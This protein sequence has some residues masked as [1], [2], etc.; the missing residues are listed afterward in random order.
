MYSVRNP[1]RPFRDGT[2]GHFFNKGVKVGMK[3]MTTFQIKLI[4]ITAMVIDHVGLFFFPQILLLRIIGRLAFPLFAWLI[5]NGA[6]YSKNINMYLIRLFLF[7]VIAQ[8]PFFLA[9]RLIEPSFWELNVLFTLFL[10]LAAIVLMR[11]SKHRFTAILVV[12]ISALLAEILNTDYGALGVLAIVIFYVYF[13][14]MK[15]M[16]ILQICLF[17][18]FSLMPIGIVM[19]FTGV[20][21]PG[22]S[23]LSTNICPIL[24]KVCLKVSTT[25]PSNF[26]VLNLIEPLGLF[27]LFFIAFYGGQEG[28]KIKYFFYLFYPMHLAV[29]Y[30]F[31]L[32]V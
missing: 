5:A 28:R 9:N 21:N 23:T 7:A 1:N 18:L 12:L 13:K 27:S 15:K 26:V 29:I 6:Y 24:M 3:Q 11:K 4:A 30:F 20:A 14:D 8:I 22:M 10:G 16:I 31:K 17:T 32:F 25:I 2:P 19:A